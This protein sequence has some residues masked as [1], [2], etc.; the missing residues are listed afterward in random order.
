VDRDADDDDDQRFARAE[1]AA[2]GWALRLIPSE[3]TNIEAFDAGVEAATVKRVCS[4]I[5]AGTPVPDLR[6]ACRSAY[7]LCLLV[8][9]YRTEGYGIA[10]DE[11]HTRVGDSLVEFIAEEPASIMQSIR[12]SASGLTTLAKRFEGIRARWPARMP[13]YAYG[14]EEDAEWIGLGLLALLGIRDAETRAAS[15]EAGPDKTDSYQ[16]RKRRNAR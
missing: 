12:H 8:G 9:F 3:D 14:L 4:K 10:T 5:S 15:D 6:E 16:G 2:R 1:D 13:A 11:C 7:R